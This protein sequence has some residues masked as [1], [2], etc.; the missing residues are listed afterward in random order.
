MYKGR[1]IGGV[2]SLVVAALLVVLIFALPE[3]KVVF[4][5]GDINVPWV[6]ALV[7]AGVG[8]WLV[9]IAGRRQGA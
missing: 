4:M 5:I 9:S 1:L 3:G 7:L 6:P 8:A 2:I